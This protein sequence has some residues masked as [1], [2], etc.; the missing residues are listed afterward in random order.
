MNEVVRAIMGMRGVGPPTTPLK[1][2][3]S[4]GVRALESPNEG[5]RGKI[6]GGDGD[7]S[8]RGSGVGAPE[9]ALGPYVS[10]GV[11]FNIPAAAGLALPRVAVPGNMVRGGRVVVT[12][13]LG[14]GE[15]GGRAGA[16]GDINP[17][18]RVDH[19]D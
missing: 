10:K 3:V 4:S 8:R 16:L 6:P 11:P 5:S 13:R 7:N 1:G 14:I 19:S 15:D 18:T 12:V 17:P 9:H 2:P